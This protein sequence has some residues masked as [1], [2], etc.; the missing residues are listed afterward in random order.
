MAKE[1]YG[2]VERERP[3]AV[4]WSDVT[5]KITDKLEEGEKAR[6]E[7]RSGV[8]SA[9]KELEEGIEGLKASERA[10]QQVF[11]SNVGYSLAN[12]NEALKDQMLAKEISQKD[13]NIAYADLKGQYNLFKSFNQNYNTSYQKYQ[14]GIQSGDYQA[15][16]MAMGDLLQKFGQ[17]D[18]LEPK[19]QNG[20]LVFQRYDSS[21][22]PIGDPMTM[23]DLN[24]LML[25]EPDKFD[26][27]A[28]VADVSKTI[29][30][31]ASKTVDGKTII[32]DPS[33]N[34]NFNEALKDLS[35]SKFADQGQIRAA[36][37]LV[38]DN[39]S[40]YKKVSF[41]T[42][43]P[44]NTETIFMT[45]K[46]GIAS[47]VPQQ[48][49]K[50]NKDAIES[51][52]EAV[53]GTL[54]FESVVRTESDKTGTVREVSKLKSGTD[55]VKSVNNVLTSGTDFQSSMSSIATTLGADDVNYVLDQNGEINA[56]VFDFPEKSKVKRTVV[57][58]KRNGQPVSNEKITEELYK[59]YTKQ[60][61]DKSSFSD[62]WKRSNIVSTTDYKP[63]KAEV[64]RKDQGLKESVVKVKTG[65]LTSAPLG[66]YLKRDDA[67]LQT[68][69]STNFRSFEKG[70]PGY[71][72]EPFRGNVSPKE[73]GENL[74]INIGKRTP[75]RN[76]PANFKIPSNL[77]PEQ[78][79]QVIESINKVLWD[80]ENLTNGQKF[81]GLLQDELDAVL[82]DD[83]VD[84][85]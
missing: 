7:E 69:Y 31:G 79:E 84:I 8:I 65:A 52:S 66:E 23:K 17:V 14:K 48:I 61:T 63:G 46:D 21:N 57:E 47:V 30:K 9:A 67:N 10:S 59:I 45:M 49:E 32:L 37:Y 73:V 38:Q 82:G 55:F 6:L 33:A 24:G 50:V 81:I 77:T 28:E 85:I 11:V 5:K 35:A 58:V 80:N 75:F 29:Q 4:N 71:V 62:V 44:N 64:F 56:Y 70:D 16:N 27:T 41:D 54:P 40:G 19:F 34:P 15:V 2:Y 60:T 78:H 51:F 68:A 72:P 20:R 3:T 25:F 43:D 74:E 13:Y 22:Q 36:N 12:A 18:D 53:R 83:V 42:Y 1:F 26:A 76:N 39:V